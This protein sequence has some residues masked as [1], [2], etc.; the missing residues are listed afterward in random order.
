MRLIPPGHVATYGQIDSI[1]S[2]RR[3]ARTVG[4]ALHGLAEDN[5]VPWH[6]VINAQGQIS[7]TCQAHEANEQ[8]TLLEQEGVIFDAQGRVDLQKYQWGGPDWP[9]FGAL[10]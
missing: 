2:H 8:R 10:R 5:D 3:A 4:W 7:T 1:V 6:R 9:E